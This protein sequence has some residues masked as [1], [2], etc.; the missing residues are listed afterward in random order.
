MKAELASKP[1]CENFHQNPESFSRKVN[2]SEIKTSSVVSQKVP[3]SHRVEFVSAT[4]PLGL[5]LSMRGEWVDP[6]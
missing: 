2:A 1:H 4:G 6:I 3:Q 5:Y